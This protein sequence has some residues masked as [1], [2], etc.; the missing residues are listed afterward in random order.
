MRVIIR[1]VALAAKLAL[2]ALVF[3]A[4]M[5]HGIACLPLAA[6][7]A[8]IIVGLP[9]SVLSICLAMVRVMDGD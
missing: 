3:G 6:L 7:E 4:T 9:R 2:A 5:A 1:L 8:M